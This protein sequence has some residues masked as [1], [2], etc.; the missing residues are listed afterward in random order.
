MR[1]FEVRVG[2]QSEALQSDQDNGRSQ[3]RDKADHEDP[4]VPFDLVEIVIHFQNDADTAEAHSCNAVKT[5]DKLCNRG[6]AV[7]RL[8]LRA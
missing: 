7:A 6:T 4:V 3:R 2:Q 5:D 1:V 8:H